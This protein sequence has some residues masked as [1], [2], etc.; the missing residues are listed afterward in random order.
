ML[1]QATRGLLVDRFLEKYRETYNIERCTEVSDTEGTTRYSLRA[2]ITY[3]EY[4]NLPDIVGV[5]MNG[6]QYIYRK[7]HLQGEDIG[8]GN[9]YVTGLLFEVAEEE[10]AK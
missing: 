4:K 10:K 1:S 8:Q 3:W 7:K 6:V 9:R 2:P 5:E